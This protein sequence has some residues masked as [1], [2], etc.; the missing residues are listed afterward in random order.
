MGRFALYFGK[1]YA[2]KRGKTLP[3][4][5]HQTSSARFFS[6]ERRSQDFTRLFFHGAAMVSS[7]DAKPC[8]YGFVELA[9]GDTSHIALMALL[10]AGQSFVI[11]LFFQAQA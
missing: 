5:F 4:R 11:C 10:A 9:D 8:L 2:S 3:N 1:I 6:G 7:S